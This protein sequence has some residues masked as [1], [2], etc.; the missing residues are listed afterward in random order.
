MAL[1]WTLDKL[2]PLARSAEDASLVLAAIAG[3]DAEDPSSVV[4]R[5]RHPRRL[6]RGLRVGAVPEDFSGAD[7]GAERAW[8][9]VLAALESAGLAVEE[10]PLPDQPFGDV[11][12]AI[13]TTEARAAFADVIAGPKLALLND[14]EQRTG[15]AA[16][17]AARGS[18]YLRAA[19][20]RAACRRAMAEMFTRYDILISP[21]YTGGAPP[22][23]ANLDTTFPAGNGRLNTAGNCTGIPC[24]A[25]PMGTTDDGLPLGFQI[26]AAA[27]QEAAA[28]SLARLYQSRTH[29]HQ[30]RPPGFA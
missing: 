25:L 5:Y 11:T 27:G 9:Q 23:D 22:V 14:P 6:A 17:M 18:D 26:C 15:L 29:W 19:Q 16:G 3:P 30:D 8:K 4:G 1:S 21:T 2:G 13:I 7:P 20:L 10:A 24:V 12:G 28:V